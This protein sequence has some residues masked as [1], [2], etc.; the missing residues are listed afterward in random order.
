MR[1]GFNRWGI[2]VCL[3]FL[4]ACAN[5]VPPDGG[6]K[7]VQAPKLIAQSVKDSQLHARVTSITLTMDEYITVADAQKP[8]RARGA[9]RAP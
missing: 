8:W 1:L 3:L 6:D 9:N 5:I 2:S 4:A 7:D